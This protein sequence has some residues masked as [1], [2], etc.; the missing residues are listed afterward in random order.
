MYS[1]SAVPVLGLSLIHIY[2][3]VG[4]TLCLGGILAIMVINA[5]LPIWLAFVV[6]LAAG[7]VVGFVNGFLVVHQKCEP[8]IITLGMGCLLYTSR[9]V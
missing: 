1:Q 6:A 8:F 4:G 7:A 9:C 5:G 2:L 3:S